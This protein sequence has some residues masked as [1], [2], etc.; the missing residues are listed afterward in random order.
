MPVKAGQIISMPVVDNG[1]I[2]TVRWQVAGP[3]A[4][5][6]PMGAQSAWRLVP[7]LTDEKGKPVSKYKMVLWLSVDARRVP[8]KFQ[9]G[10]P[11]GSFTLTLSKITP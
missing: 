10:L 3:E 4:V 1:D 6:T 9:A 11:V 2:Y 8:L 5:A 7:A